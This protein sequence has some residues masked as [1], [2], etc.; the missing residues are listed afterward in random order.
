MGNVG[1]GTSGGYRVG[2]GGGEHFCQLSYIFSVSRGFMYS[3]K[4]Y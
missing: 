1:I 2:R 3:G 4:W